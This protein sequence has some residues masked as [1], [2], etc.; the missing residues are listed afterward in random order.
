MLVNG[1]W[2]AHELIF[3]TLAQFVLPRSIILLCLSTQNI[4]KFYLMLTGEYFSS[5]QS[6]TRSIS[7]TT[8]EKMSG[9]LQS[10]T[11]VPQKEQSRDEPKSVVSS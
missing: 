5:Y 1:N 10:F 7:E 3:D 2:C 9:L 8:L 11:M 6:V 4:G